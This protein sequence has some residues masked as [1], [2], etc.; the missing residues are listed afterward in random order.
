MV[1]FKENWVDV[2]VVTWQKD[3]NVYCE[4][5]PKL[6]AALNYKKDLEMDGYTDVE[7]WTKTIYLKDIEQA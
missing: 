2:H 7:I 4:V 5:F 1:T 6:D 3:G